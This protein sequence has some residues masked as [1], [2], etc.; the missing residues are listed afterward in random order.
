[1]EA[2]AVA[3]HKARLA[4]SPEVAEVCTSNPIQFMSDVQSWIKRG[5]TLDLSRTIFHMSFYET[6]MNAPAK[7]A[8][9][10]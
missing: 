2:A 6:F 8:K 3:A 10:S 1:A 9:A 7:R 5:Y 4:E